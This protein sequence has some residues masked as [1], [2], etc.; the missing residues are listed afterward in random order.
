MPISPAN[1]IKMCRPLVT[2]ETFINFM[3]ENKLENLIIICNHACMQTTKTRAGQ[4]GSLARHDPAQHVDKSRPNR[5]V[6]NPTQQ[7]YVDEPVGWG[8][9]TMNRHGP[10]W[11]ANPAQAARH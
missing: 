4:S 6:L 5:A 3:Y 10:A 2:K 1:E 9:R 8:V 11:C 7:A